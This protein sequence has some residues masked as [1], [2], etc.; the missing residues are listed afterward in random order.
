MV[1]VLFYLPGYKQVSVETFENLEAA[2]K[3]MTEN[4]PS[5]FTAITVTGP[6]STAHWTKAQLVG[7]FNGLDPSAEKVKGFESL[8]E[9]E[10][11]VFER[12][13]NWKPQPAPEGATEEKSTMATA[14]K[15]KAAKKKAAKA[16]SATPRKVAPLTVELGDNL[17][18]GADVTCG[19]Y[20]RTLVMKGKGTDEILKLVGKHYPDSTAKGSDVSWNR[21]KLKA[22][23]KKVPDAPRA[24][25][26]EE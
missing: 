5:A 19:C 23:G 18:P 6:E 15:K 26:K 16:K 14:T 21:A 4:K 22:A 7:I 25:A 20:I 3:G 8:E 10:K 24:N 12:I 1:Y 17:K 13:V 11:R 9:G 2:Q